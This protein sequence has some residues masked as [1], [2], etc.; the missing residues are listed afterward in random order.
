MYEAPECQLGLLVTSAYDIWSLG[1]IFLEFI[2]WLRHGSA[3]LLVFSSDRLR[4]DPLLG[5]R[6]I[7]DYFF[8]LIYEEDAPV[9]AEVRSSV[10]SWIDR[11][12]EDCS[13]RCALRDVLRI[14]ERDLLVVDPEKRIKAHE[15]L[16][17]LNVIVAGAETSAGTEASKS[18]KDHPPN[19]VFSDD[20]NSGF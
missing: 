18:Q 3:G 2:I 7:D 4:A 20:K 8:S 10:R 14:V 1:A 9:N 5:A 15:L 17:K 11:L 12:G 16:A 6:W 19:V 13:D